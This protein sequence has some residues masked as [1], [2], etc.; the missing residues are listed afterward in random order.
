MY[1]VGTTVL[2]LHLWSESNFIVIGNKL[3][4]LAEIDKATCLC[5][6]GICCLSI[7][8]DLQKI[9]VAVDIEIDGTKFLLAVRCVSEYTQEKAPSQKEYR[10]LIIELNK[11][12]IQNL[13]SNSNVSVEKRQTTQSALTKSTQ[14]VVQ[15]QNNISGAD[16][17]GVN[18]RIHF[19]FEKFRQQKEKN[20]QLT[21]TVITPEI[22]PET[23]HN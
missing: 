13:N 10:Y 17:R 5:N 3:G 6:P 16:S 4:G 15:N 12:K 19:L 18:N 22:V 9:P 20:R 23:I 1:L 2:P 14:G 7:T 11:F 21:E 8:G